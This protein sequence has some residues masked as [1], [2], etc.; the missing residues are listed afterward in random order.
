MADEE[1]WAV[2]P[3]WEQVAGL[4]LPVSTLVTRMPESP[5]SLRARCQPGKYSGLNV[6]NRVLGCSLENPVK[7]SLPGVLLIEITRNMELPRALLG[8]W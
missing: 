8:V 4:L 7:A 5:E 2:L 3:G 6:R 1:S